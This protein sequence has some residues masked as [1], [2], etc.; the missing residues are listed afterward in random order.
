MQMLSLVAFES[1]GPV[2]DE[3]FAARL[4]GSADGAPTHRWRP[5][6]GQ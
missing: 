3:D 5:M 2:L 4:A 6:L 1:L